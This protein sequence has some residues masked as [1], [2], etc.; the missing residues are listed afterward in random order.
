MF[1]FSNNGLQ[2]ELGK[3]GTCVRKT[4][5]GGRG[6]KRERSFSFILARSPLLFFAAALFP[7]RSTSFFYPA[8]FFCW[9]LIAMA[10]TAEPPPTIPTAVRPHLSLRLLIWTEEFFFG[11]EG[12]VVSVSRPQGFE[13]LLYLFLLISLFVRIDLPPGRRTCAWRGR[14]RAP[15]LFESWSFFCFSRGREKRGGRG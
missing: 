8:A 15:V 1:L 2:N 11:G 12:G 10:T 7:P 3:K 9:W 5:A 13:K 4:R 14:S 6:K